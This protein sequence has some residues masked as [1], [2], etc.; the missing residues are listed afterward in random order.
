MTRP[1]KYSKAEILNAIQSLVASGI[2]VNPRNVRNRLGGGNF[3][4]IKE[5]IAEFSLAERPNSVAFPDELADTFKRA[6]QAF[7]RQLDELS[8]EAWRIALSNTAT[9]PD[10]TPAN[11]SSNAREEENGLR[12]QVLMLQKQCADLTMAWRNA[13]SDFRSSQRTIDILE[14]E[15]QR[16]RE[17]IRS[18]FKQLEELSRENARLKSRL[19]LGLTAS[20]KRGS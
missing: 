18:M 4:R 5:V 15:K 6:S 2:I 20:K 3:D 11:A 9:L 14:R 12:Q 17:E 7:A 10:R 19:D 1:Q 8:L 16:D 13:E